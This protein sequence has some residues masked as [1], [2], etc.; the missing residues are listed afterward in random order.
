MPEESLEMSLRVA[1]LGLH[2][3]FDS[4]M[5]AGFSREEAFQL[6]QIVLHTQLSN[7][8]K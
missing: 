6:V 7:G 4:Y 3:L 8:K 1:A 5:K 2:E